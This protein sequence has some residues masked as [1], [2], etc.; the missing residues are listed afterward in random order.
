MAGGLISYFGISTRHAFSYAY[1]IYNTCFS[2]TI[3]DK[4]RGIKEA[5]KMNRK[6]VIPLGWA[7]FNHT[8]KPKKKKKKEEKCVQVGK[9][10][11]LCMLF[12]GLDNLPVYCKFRKN[13]E[14]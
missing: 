13:K 2:T 11:C 7:S 9:E 5:S 4:K 12:D 6:E 14:E 1:L 10:A 8:A 3:P